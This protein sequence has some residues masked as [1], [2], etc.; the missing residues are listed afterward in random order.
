MRHGR[1]EESGARKRGTPGL[2]EKH[3]PAAS[4]FI[5]NA[6]A[7]FHSLCLPRVVFLEYHQDV[8]AILIYFTSSVGVSII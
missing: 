2:S 4:A 3:L 1:D 6:I 5:E 8:R 7:K